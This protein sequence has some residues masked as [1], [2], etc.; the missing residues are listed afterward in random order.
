METT[1]FQIYSN[2]KFSNTASTTTGI[3]CVENET[4]STN[5]ATYNMA[6]QQVDNN[7]KGII[8]RKGKKIIRK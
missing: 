5:T 2:S 1:N 8:I 6:G 4:I 7:Y 3:S